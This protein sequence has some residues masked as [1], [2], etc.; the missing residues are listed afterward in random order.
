[1]FGAEAECR[2][3]M[4]HGDL[5]DK[6]VPGAF[7]SLVVWQKAQGLAA[8]I[9]ELVAALPRDRATDAIV[10]Q[11]IRSAGSIPANV[12]EGYGRFA[13][14]AY[15]NHLSIARGSLF[16]TESWID[17][18]IRLNRVEMAEGGRLARRCE[19]VSRLITATMRSLPGS[20]A[21]RIR[22]EGGDYDASF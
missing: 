9:V 4:N 1:M 16:E 17:L 14:G 8:A 20:A 22:E 5:S 6:P 19:E 10:A 2:V 18:L 12:A 11:L 21:R 7:R 13:D 3:Q 15:R